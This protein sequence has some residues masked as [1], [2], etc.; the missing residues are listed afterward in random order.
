MLQ[1][2]MTANFLNIY[3]VELG[4]DYEDCHEE[5]DCRDSVHGHFLLFSFSLFVAGGCELKIHWRNV[6]FYTAPGALVA[7]R[8]PYVIQVMVM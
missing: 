1:H 3:L 7:C 4:G 6:P 2:Q 5:N 8:K